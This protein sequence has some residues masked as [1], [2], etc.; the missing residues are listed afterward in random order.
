LHFA[1]QIRTLNID[2]AANCLARFKSNRSIGIIV[3]LAI[4]AE[5]MAN[6]R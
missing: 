3:F 6:L 2:N 5:M 4:C 1:W